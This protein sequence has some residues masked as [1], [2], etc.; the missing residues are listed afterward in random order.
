MTMLDVLTHLVLISALATLDLQEM[1]SSVKV[2]IKIECVFR[3]NLFES[4]R[5]TGITLTR[6]TVQL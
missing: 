5:T 6:N 2:K 4:S 3:M 1:G